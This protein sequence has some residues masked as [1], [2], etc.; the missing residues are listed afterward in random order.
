M[1][2][3]TLLILKISLIWAVEDDGKHPGSLDEGHTH[4]RTV[5]FEAKHNC[6]AT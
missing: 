2:Q 3:Q 5:A 1:L 4:K 6:G